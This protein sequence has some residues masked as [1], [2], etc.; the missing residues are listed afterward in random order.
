[1]RHAESEHNVL[2]IVNGDP[3]KQFH[4]TKKGKLQ[5]K[6]LALKLRNKEIAAVIASQMKR[7][8]DTAAPLA[9]L[10]KLK[11][12]IDSRLNDIGT[13]GLEGMNILKFKKI[14]NL[15]SRS[16]KGSETGV[17]VAK[18]LKSFLEDAVKYYAG[19][20]IAVVSSEIILHSL[21][22]IAAGKFSNEHI[23][24]HPKNATVYTFHL[25]SPIC[26]PSC[27]DRCEI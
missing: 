25:H 22:Q 15:V 3:K 19:K 24:R 9:K 18:R 4:I 21:K 13:G 16:V 8:Q 17:G 12:Q 11:I 5:A 14:T 23:G 6:G 27:G 26:C 20:T 10:K 1:M 2:N 7:T